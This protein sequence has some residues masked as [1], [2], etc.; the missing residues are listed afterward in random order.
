MEKEKIETLAVKPEVSF[1]E[2][3]TLNLII[4]IE[5]ESRL[6]SKIND[7]ED[8]MKNNSGKGKKE[9]EKDQLYKSSQELWHSFVSSLKEAK[10]NFYLNRPQH[11]FLTD[12]IITK[13]EYDVNT[14]FFAIELTNMLGNMK[15]A[16]Y[17]NDKDL[18]PFPVNATEITYIYHLIS[19]H[20]VKGLNKDAYL[21]SQ[22]LYRIGSI[23]K[24]FNYYES[25]SKT[26]AK[27][28]QDWVLTFEE[29]I[30]LDKSKDSVEGNVIE[31]QS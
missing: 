8:F 7:I 12:L 16:K 26:L 13:M 30:S 20:K 23:S 14:V 28:I 11:K 4:S 17:T 31:P 21:F 22:I 19:K 18:I 2:N 25:S 9:E 6:D 10:Y 15:E 3:D 27:D 5:E 29:G 24:I 1:M